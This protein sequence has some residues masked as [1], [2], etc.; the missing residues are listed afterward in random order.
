MAVSLGDVNPVGKLDIGS[1]GLGLL[2]FF[3]VVL[4]LGGIGFAIYM[5]MQKKKLKYIIPLYKMIGARPIKIATYKAMDFKVGF[6]GDVL[7]YVP[8]KKKYISMGTIQTAPN[9]YP[10]FER[11][12]GEWINFG[13]GDIDAQMKLA[14]VKYVHSDMRSQRIAISNMLENRFKGKQSWWDKYGSI[15]TMVIF[16]LV[17]AIAMVIIFFQWGKIIEGTNTLV[18]KIDVLQNGKCPATTT[19]VVPAIALFL[20]KPFR[21]KRKN[22]IS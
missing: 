9:E 8:K 14:N 20:I 1:I 17:V 16:Y 22:G 5:R 10:H 2:I 13:L 21:R 6:A 12:D 15:V 4:I 3:L 19:G 11:E 18:D 7:W